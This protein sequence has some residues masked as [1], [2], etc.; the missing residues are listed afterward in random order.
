[1]THPFDPKAGCRHYRASAVI[2]QAKRAERVRDMKVG[3]EV[4]SFFGANIR[5]YKLR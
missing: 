1:M 3:I 4:F 2:C 5:A